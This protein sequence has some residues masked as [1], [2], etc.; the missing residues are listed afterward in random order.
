MR[1]LT[2]S[3]GHQFAYYRAEP[4]GQARGAVLVIPEIFGVNAHIRSVCDGYA[5]D[6]YVALSPSVFDRV[7]RGVELGYGPEDV[8]RGIALM[9]PLRLG[10]VLKDLQAALDELS[11]LGR[12]GVVGYCYGGSLAWTAACR[13]THL[14]A[15]S[16]YYGGQISHQIDSVPRVPTILHF[17]E[18]D[19]MISMADVERVRTAHPEVPVYVYPTGHGFNCDARPGYHPESAKLARQ[20][21]LAL[22]AEH[23]G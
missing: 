8:R 3:D 10:D 19:P 21:T 9:G 11:K 16:G 22:F 1:T 23:V 12:V 5:S 17:G 15:A 18:Q 20:R 14:A 4:A 13:L 7:E 6:G 2:A